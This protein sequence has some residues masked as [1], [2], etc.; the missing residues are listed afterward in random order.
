MLDLALFPTW[1]GPGLALVPVGMAVGALRRG[2]A[3]TTTTPSTP[4]PIHN[5]TGTPPSA[6]GSVTNGSATVVDVVV[7]VVTSGARVRLFRLVNELGLGLGPGSAPGLGLGQWSEQGL[8][9]VLVRTPLFDDS[10]PHILF[11]F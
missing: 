7:G 8:A 6:L 10:F 4:S 3:S 5:A 11:G 2:V 9:L 1:S